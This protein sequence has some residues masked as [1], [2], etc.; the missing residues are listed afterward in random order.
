M[1][2]GVELIAEERRRQI[3]VEG[4]TPEHDDEH[5]NGELAR[6]AICYARP[7]PKG[8]KR[9]KDEW[10]WDMSWWKPALPEM[11]EHFHGR[12]QAGDPVGISINDEAWRKANIRNLV[13]A[14][15]L[16]AA[17]IDRIMRME[18]TT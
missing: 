4:W 8:G 2:S 18:P 17:E 12:E 7:S 6:A 3:E 1:K 9:L 16:I 11:T 15:A 13:K 14:G 5:T 10:P